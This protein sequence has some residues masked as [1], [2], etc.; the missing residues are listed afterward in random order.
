VQVVAGQAVQLLP[1]AFTGMSTAA[2]GDRQGLTFNNGAATAPAD[3]PA[4]D[5]AGLT[6]L[7][8]GPPD[9]IF[10]EKG[11]SSG[12]TFGA[13]DADQLQAACLITPPGQ[14]SGAPFNIQG[15]IDGHTGQS[16]QWPAS[17]ALA[18]Q[19]CSST[20]ASP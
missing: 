10:V 13:A 14:Y 19:P 18:G 8:S 11:Y 7:L 3:F 6:Q 9:T 15:V 20:Y 17:H 1:V 5:Q 12:F 2:L 4:A 16:L